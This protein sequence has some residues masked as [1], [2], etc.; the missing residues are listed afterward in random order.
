MFESARQLAEVID[1]TLVRPDATISDLEQACNDARHYGFA[2]LIVNSWHAGR[3]KN[4]LAGSTVKLGVVV[5]FPHG[6]CT[7]TVKIVEAMEAV[8]N[9]AEEIDIMLN[10]GLVKSGRLDLAEIDVKNVAAMTKQSLHK[11]ILET[12]RLTT[13]EI[14]AV[15]KIFARTGIAF[16]KTCSGF[17]PRGA[18]SDD[19]RMIS[20]AV[21]GACRVKAS[22]GIG[23]LDS[24]LAMVEAGAARIGTS[25]GPAIMEEFLRRG[26][27]I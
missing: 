20:E 1:H 7:T 18:T 10:A 17:G 26:A 15:S 9:G 2:A 23:D 14:R 16:I 25:S 27:V 12:G 19:V 6:A 8:K 24:L 22:G 5:G 4:L 3:A 11:V 21:A 13:A